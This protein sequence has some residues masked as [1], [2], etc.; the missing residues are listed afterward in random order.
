MQF[1]TCGRL[2]PLKLLLSLPVR[3]ISI[4]SPC[5]PPLTLVARLFH[6]NIFALLPAIFTL[7][8]SYLIGI[9]CLLFATGFKV[10]DQLR[11]SYDATLSTID[12]EAQA[13]AHGKLWEAKQ[14]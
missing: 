11:D 14:R 7:S 12:F 13:D 8:H 1:T 4:F 10:S 9:L 6:L 3:F 2:F 5:C